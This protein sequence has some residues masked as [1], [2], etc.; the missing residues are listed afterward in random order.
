MSPYS[1]ILADDHTALRQNLKNLI[2]Q[3]K[4]LEVVGEA[5]DGIGLLGLLRRA[6]RTPDLVIVDITMP[7]LGGIETTHRIKEI[8]PDAKVLVLTIHTEREYIEKAFSAGAE[9]YL[10]KDRMS[11][12]LFAAIAKIREGKV[13]VS[14]QDSG[15]LAGEQQ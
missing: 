11:S 5:A 13:Y 15:S 1:I 9:G 10:L 4:D 14:L 8:Y 12:E 6:D 2:A 3:N 7:G